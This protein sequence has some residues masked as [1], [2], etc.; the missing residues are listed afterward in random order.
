MHPT[1][2]APVLRLLRRTAQVAAAALFVGAIS[3]AVAQAQ[4]ADGSPP[5][6]GKAGAPKA[7]AEA[8]P[9]PLPAAKTAEVL[10]KVQAFYDNTTSFVSTFTQQYRIKA[11]SKTKTSSGTVIFSKPGKMDWAYTDPKDNRVVSDGVTI[12]VYEAANKQMFEQPM[13]KSQYPAVLSF[14]TGEGKLSDTFTFEL[15][16]G[17]E[18]NFPGG[19]V[20]SGTPKTETPAYSRVLFY[21]D[22]ASSQV[23]RVLIID[24]QGNRNRFDF[25][26]PKVNVPVDASHFRFA[27]PPGTTVVRP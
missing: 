20:L 23:R 1:S 22:T 2:S 24:G 19:Y 7:G 9:K 13:G 16:A 25:D 5:P 17:E 3:G 8:L 4:T 27:P 14:L 11:H 10:A 15:Y 26:T 18:A 21:V 6:A 12:K